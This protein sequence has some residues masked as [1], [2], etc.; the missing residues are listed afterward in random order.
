M[1]DSTESCS[2][3]SSDSQPMHMMFFCKYAV[4]SVQAMIFTCSLLCGWVVVLWSKSWDNGCTIVS[5]HPLHAFY[6]LCRLLASIHMQIRWERFN[7]NCEFSYSAVY[8][9]PGDRTR[10]LYVASPA[11]KWCFWNT[12]FHFQLLII[13]EWMFYSPLIQRLMVLQYENHYHSGLLLTKCTNLHMKYSEPQASG[14][15]FC[16]FHHSVHTWQTM[17]FGITLTVLF[18]NAQCPPNGLNCAVDL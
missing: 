4:F 16:C 13:T 8:V 17:L 1:W 18:M 6:I 3:N 7:R 15:K 11:Y 2:G 9:V 10:D 12:A 5:I 14:M